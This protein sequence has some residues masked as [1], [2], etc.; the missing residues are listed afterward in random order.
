MKRIV[1]III[2]LLLVVG[3][4][5][6]F[7]RPFGAV[8]TGYL[9]TILATTATLAGIGFALYGWYTITELPKQ[10]ERQVAPKIREMESSFRSELYRTQNAMQ[11]VLSSYSMTDADRKVEL[12]QEAVSIEPQVFNGYIALG[13]AYWYDQIDF[14][15]ADECFRKYLEYHPDSFEAACDLAALAASQQE[16]NG[17]LGWLNQAVKMNPNSKQSIAKDRRFDELRRQKPIECQT[18]IED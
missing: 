14:V 15:K 10:I 1:P 2:A 12:L 7:F 8:D 17:A 18:M 4:S 5:L 9:L 16:W 6:P 3:F 11:K 13:Y